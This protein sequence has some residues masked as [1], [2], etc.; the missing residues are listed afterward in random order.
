M[1]SLRF[2]YFTTN[3][4]IW[5]PSKTVLPLVRQHLLPL[6][7]SPKI[8]TLVEGNLTFYYC[9]TGSYVFTDPRVAVSLW[10]LRETYSSV[11]QNWFKL[12]WWFLSWPMKLFKLCQICCFGFAQFLCLVNC[13]STEKIFKEV[14]LISKTNENREVLIFKVTTLYWARIKTLLVTLHVLFLKSSSIPFPHWKKW[15][16]QCISNLENVSNEW[17]FKSSYM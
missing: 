14:I 11:K 2:P 17:T 10:G 3:N 1:S 15:C 6:K 8:N 16:L 7:Y 5:L 4:L 12:D 13:I 9:S